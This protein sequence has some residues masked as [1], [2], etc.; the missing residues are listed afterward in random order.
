MAELSR[1]AKGFRT[2]NP[3]TVDLLSW[4][5]CPSVQLFAADAVEL[6]RVR[7][8]SALTPQGHDRDV[9]RLFGPSHKCFD[10][11]QQL[12]DDGASTQ[13]LTIRQ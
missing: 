8:R 10:V 6:V 11:L 13:L 4:I 3:D 12:F 7:C 5:G 9:V 1:S 2:N